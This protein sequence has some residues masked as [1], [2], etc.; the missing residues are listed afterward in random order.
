MRMDRRDWLGRMLAGVAACGVPKTGAS[1]LGVGSL[2]GVSSSARA[3]TP[4]WR[5]NERIP[6]P[7]AASGGASGAS[8]ASGAAADGARTID[9]KALVPA[10]WDPLKS[11]RSLD[12][13]RLSDA[14]PRAQEAME[15]LQREW[16][17]A[18]PVRAMDGARVRLAGFVAP[19]DRDPKRVRQFLLVPYFGACIHVPPPPANQIVHVVPRTPMDVQWASDAVWVT[20]VLR[21]DTVDTEIG[22]AG[23]MIADAV[24]ERHERSERFERIR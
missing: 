1:L 5:L 6:E 18:P 24:V 10:D 19:L 20:G 3:E 17:R 8:S 9:W 7:S 15:A 22:S 14:D 16:R 11:I 12:L 13:A 2:S 23:Y 21:V 4:R